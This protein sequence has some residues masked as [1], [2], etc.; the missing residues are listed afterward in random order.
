MTPISTIHFLEDDTPG[1]SPVSG[2]SR[3]DVILSPPAMNDTTIE[4]TAV[5]DIYNDLFESC[6]DFYGGETIAPEIARSESTI[7]EGPDDFPLEL[8]GEV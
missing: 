6:G 2:G 1:F 7:E 5:E 3:R 4:D 8:G